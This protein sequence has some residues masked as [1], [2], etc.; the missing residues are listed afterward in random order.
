[1][2][3]SDPGIFFLARPGL[4]VH[5]PGERFIILI[6]KGRDLHSGFAP[7]IDEESRQFHLLTLDPAECEF[8]RDR[9]VNRIAFVGYPNKMATTRQG[10]MSITPI[11]GFGNQGAPAPYKEEEAT[12]ALQPLPALGTIEV[13][14]NR[15]A[16]ESIMNAWNQDQYSGI[17]GID[18]REELRQKTFVDESG[19]KRP[20]GG[21]ILHPIIDEE[22]IKVRRARYQDHESISM[23]YDILGIRKHIYK[24]VQDKIANQHI[25]PLP[26]QRPP[27][28]FVP[29]RQQ[30]INRSIYAKGHDKEL[31]S[32]SPLTV[33]ESSD[34]EGGLGTDHNVCDVS[35]IIIESE[36]EVD[37]PASGAEG[38]LEEE[39]GD[40]LMDEDN[41]G[42]DDAEVDYDVLGRADSPSDGEPNEIDGTEGEMSDTADKDM[43]LGIVERFLDDELCEVLTLFF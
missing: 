5:T 36:D 33:L 38:D 22:F 32:L 28:A 18:P 25:S 7:S 13:A 8:F 2:S 43:G 10:T 9:R 40:E 23:Q 41:S 6:F 16:R 20:C 11:T 34:E 3:G 27:L 31:R 17:E 39:A 1:M 26:P 37:L 29:V 19:I 30:N 35:S 14:C 21:P 15:L 4:Y 12:Y 24:T 42:V